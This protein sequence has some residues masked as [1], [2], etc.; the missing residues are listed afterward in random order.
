MGTFKFNK[1][2]PDMVSG[3]IQKLE[4]T[5]LAVYKP[6]VFFREELEKHS[7]E[8]VAALQTKLSKHIEFF[9]KGSSSLLYFA[10]T[11]MNFVS[12]ILGTDES[13][14]VETIPQNTRA[15]QQYEFSYESMS[16]EI[17][18]NA[19]TLKTAKK[20]FS[21]NLDSL[22]ELLN[23]FE[24]ILNDV[25]FHTH[26]PWGDV[27]EVWEEGKIQ[28]NFLLTTFLKSVEELDSDADGIIKEL[29]RVDNLIAHNL[30]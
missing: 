1:D 19:Y 22:S 8:A 2:L 7:G 24:K 16:D 14:E 27:T 23:E 17:K 13:G 29:E 25:I 15:V 6:M 12:M 18:L 3:S 21:T 26:F 5:I 9:N 4:N 11:I 20:D 10:D 30:R 28:V